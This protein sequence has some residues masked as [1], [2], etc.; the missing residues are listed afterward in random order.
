VGYTRGG[1]GDTCDDSS[2]LKNWVV[3]FER[4]AT[5]CLCAIRG[6]YNERQGERIGSRP[7]NN[8]ERE[9]N[10]LIE[11]A[12]AIMYSIVKKGEPAKTLQLM[13]GTSKKGLG[14]D[15]GEKLAKSCQNRR[16]MQSEN[17]RTRGVARGKG[18]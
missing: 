10:S 13:G 16:K 6:P 9:E 2:S 15:R 5:A 11:R 17:Q 14:G 7:H 18:G 12:D 4:K 8:K 1:E 3:N